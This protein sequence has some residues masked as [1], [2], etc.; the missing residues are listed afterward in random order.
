M[1]GTRDVGPHEKNEQRATGLF[2]TIRDLIIAGAFFLIGYASVKFYKVQTAGVHWEPLS[3]DGIDA[4]ARK[5]D[6]GAPPLL[7]ASEPIPV[8]LIGAM[9]CGTTSLYDALTTIDRVYRG[10]CTLP[11]T[12]GFPRGAHCAGDKELW[13]FLHKESHARGR[14]FF[15]AHFADEAFAPSWKPRYVVDGMGYM[16]Y[17]HVPPKI[18]EMF[19]NAKVIV[20]LCDPGRR[21]LSHFRMYLHLLSHG[22]NLNAEHGPPLR[23]FR[24]A[25]NSTHRLTKDQATMQWTE[26]VNSAHL[27]TRELVFDYRMTGHY[28]LQLDMW[29]RFFPAENILVVDNFFDAPESALKAITDFLNVDE[30]RGA[31]YRTNAEA[32]KTIENALQLQKLEKGHYQHS[33]GSKALKFAVPPIDDDDWAVV[34]ELEQYYSAFN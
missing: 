34:R 16:I 20:T 1:I 13:F 9:K 18:H 29:R 30:Y 19:P 32:S 7:P 6:G 28:A 15:F 5:P 26:I 27:N 24:S 21:A 17:P 2:T 33:G 4:S 31:I 25:M 3:S 22:F 12:K 10:N 11:T 23:S 14:P 8:F